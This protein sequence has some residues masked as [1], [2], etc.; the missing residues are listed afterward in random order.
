MKALTAQRLREV[1]S[2]DATTGRFV[3]VGT[4]K[5]AGTVKSNGYLHFSVDGKKYGAHRLAWLFVHGKWPE[6]ETDHINGIR[7]DNRIANLRQ[8][9]RTLNAQNQRRAHAS[10]TH[11]IL[12]VSLD[13]STN[14]WRVRISVD[15]RNRSVGNFDTPEAARDAYIVA[16][17]RMHAGCT[18]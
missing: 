16:K 11:G 8:A 12:G 10:S 3:R 14:R 9:S 13:K 17:R 18:L 5:P 7:H 2:Y 6:G 4:G 1:V 15:G